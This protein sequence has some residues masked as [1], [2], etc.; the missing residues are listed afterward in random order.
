[1]ILEQLENLVKIK[2]LKAEPPDQ[3]EFDGIVSSAM[4]RLQDAAIEGL[5]DEGR[6]S[7]AYGAAHAFAL[8]SM[9]WHGYRS[10]NRYLARISHQKDEPSLDL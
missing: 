4:R 10:E 2:K 5:S 9:R 6:F 8:A 7:L 1:M 3:D